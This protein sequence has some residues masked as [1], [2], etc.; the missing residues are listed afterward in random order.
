MNKIEADPIAAEPDYPYQ[1]HMGYRM[2]GWGAGFARFE[3][4]LCEEHENRHGLPH[5]G[6]YATLLDSAMGFSGCYTGDPEDRLMAVTMSL[7]TNF[8]ARPTGKLLIAEGRRTGGGRTT[9]FA[10]GRITDGDGVPIATGT[11]VFR[12][13]GGKTAS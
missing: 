1:R 9:F 8:L 12:Y 4:T 13:R 7:N 11:G 2:T 6:V 3:L 5:G 10:E